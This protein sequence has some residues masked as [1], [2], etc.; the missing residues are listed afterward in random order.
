MNKQKILAKFMEKEH[1]LN[2]L[3]DSTMFESKSPQLSSLY[4]SYLDGIKSEAD[5]NIMANLQSIKEEIH[6][7]IKFAVEVLSLIKEIAEGKVDIMTLSIAN[8]AIKILEDE[9]KS[10]ENAQAPA[11]FETLKIVNGNNPEHLNR[12][13]NP[14]KNINREMEDSLEKKPISNGRD[15]SDVI[16][17]KETIIT[18]LEISNNHHKNKEGGFE[19]WSEPSSPLNKTQPPPK[20]QEGYSKYLSTEDINPDYEIIYLQGASKDELEESYRYINE[21]EIVGIDTEF[22]GKGA[23]Y[24]Q[25]STLE[26]GYIYNLIYDQDKLRFDEDFRKFLFNF[27]GNEKITKVGLCLD[28]DIEAIR[29]AMQYRIN[30]EGFSGWK[31]IHDL[32]MLSRTSNSLGLSDYT[33]RVLGIVIYNNRQTNEQGTSTMGCRERRA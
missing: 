9:I 33:S 32:V 24:I 3:K 10:E 29:K 23:N 18:D 28:A 14:K 15:Q 21:Q 6:N 2:F 26:K 11:Q 17:A 25:I 30:Q 5:S 7:P 4:I 19:S 13:L 1:T 27:C 20:K 8:S 22:F 12:F 31:D 16:E